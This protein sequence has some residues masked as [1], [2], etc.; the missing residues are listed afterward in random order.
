MKTRYMHAL[1]APVLV[2]AMLAGAQGSSAALAKAP[3]WV[4]TKGKVVTLTLIAG[5]KNAA[6]GFN[7]DGYAKGKLTITVPLGDTVNVVFSNSSSLPHSAQF[8]AAAK[9]PP[10]AAV[11]DVF[12]GANSP[13]P[14]SGVTS[15]KTQK[16]S[17]KASKA[18]TFMV[19]CAVPGHAL[20]GMW[21][22][23]VVSKTAK[24]ATVTE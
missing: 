9:T 14:T 10:A 1:A 23:F 7:F 2:A 20:A 6:G 19:I 3:T 12:A 21:D 5:Y 18:G 16:F 11:P 22:S 8:I 15:G 13:D 17:F 4:A 24:S